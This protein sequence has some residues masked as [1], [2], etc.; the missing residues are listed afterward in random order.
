MSSNILFKFHKWVVDA[1][2]IDKCSVVDFLEDLD[3]ED[4]HWL[5]V[6][7][8]D[9][10]ALDFSRNLDPATSDLL[11]NKNNHKILRTWLAGNREDKLIEFED[12]T[13]E[14]VYLRKD[15]FGNSSIILAAASSLHTSP[16]TEVWVELALNTYNSLQKINTL[17]SA[18]RLSYLTKT[19]SEISNMSKITLDNIK[20]NFLNSVAPHI[21]YGYVHEEFGPMIFDADPQEMLKPDYMIVAVKLYSG[22]DGE[23]VAE[24]GHVFKNDPLKDPELGDV[25]SIVFSLP[26]GKA[27]G[28]FE[29]HSISLLIPQEFYNLSRSL[30]GEFK[31]KLFAQVEKIRLLHEENSWGLAVTPFGSSENLKEEIHPIL[32]ELRSDIALSFALMMDPDDVINW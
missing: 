4:V 15:N 14:V 9:I 5:I 6:T 30:I 7:S 17:E 8:K 24:M 31:A 32:V 27:R 11:T 3:Y 26:N 25:F 10:Y 23:M 18:L 20:P 16:E 21:F 22:L 19:R 2:S 28:G 12:D 29:M 13:R 1:E